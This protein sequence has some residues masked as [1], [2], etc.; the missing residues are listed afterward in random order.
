[1]CYSDFDDIIDAIAEMD[2]DVLL[3]EGA[4]SGMRILD[5]LRRGRYPGEVGPGV[6]DVHSPRVPSP[7]EIEAL[8]RQAGRVFPADRLWVNPDCGLKTRRWEEVRPALAAMVA[9]ARR[10]RAEHDE[11]VAARPHTHDRQGR[12][13]R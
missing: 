1:M 9:A 4:R 10:L 3:V 12:M 8:L 2:A 11:P 5:L 13:L 6:Y 7:E